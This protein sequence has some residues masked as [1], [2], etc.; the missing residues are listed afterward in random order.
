MDTAY[1]NLNTAISL[2]AAPID[3]ADSMEMTS[4]ENS[5]VVTL[6]G[7]FEIDEI[8]V[9]TNYEDEAAYNYIVYISEDG[10]TW[11]KVGEQT[12]DVTATESGYVHAVDHVS[13]KYIM[14]ESEDTLRR[15]AFW[16]CED[17]WDDEI[18]LLWSSW[19]HM[20]VIFY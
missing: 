14:I 1:D 10:D 12:G 5:V 13:A 16:E 3:V 2:L 20:A 18:A 6:D 15:G 7:I 8:V 19:V 9:V 11:T 17:E 4:T